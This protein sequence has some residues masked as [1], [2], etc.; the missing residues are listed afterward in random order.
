MCSL[1]LTPI[2][3]WK[4]NALVPAPRSR[5][6]I[7]RKLWLVSDTDV[8]GVELGILRDPIGHECFFFFRVEKL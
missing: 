2:C 5:D 3:R 1:P 8:I 7:V 4:A 6:R